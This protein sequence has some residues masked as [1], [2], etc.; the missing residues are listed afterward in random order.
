[1]VYFTATFFWNNLLLLR[2]LCLWCSGP[3]LKWVGQFT[4]VIMVMGVNTQGKYILSSF[5]GKQWSYDNIKLDIVHV[6][7]HCNAMFARQEVVGRGCWHWSLLRQSFFFTHLI[8]MALQSPPP[9]DGN[10]IL[11]CISGS[12]GLKGKEMP[13]RYVNTIELKQLAF[14]HTA[15]W[16]TL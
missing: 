4:E 8:L 15:C 13:F 16:P 10:K 11:L 3:I 9:L 7:N 1:M 6:L 12:E 5:S 2:C 14:A